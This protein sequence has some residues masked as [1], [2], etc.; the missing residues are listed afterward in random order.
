MTEST[1]EKAHAAL[2]APME[3][4]NDAG[5]ETVRAYLA[6]LLQTLWREEEGFNGKRPFGNSGWQSDIHLALVNAGLIP[7]TFDEDGCLDSVDEEAADAV[8]LA[9]IDELGRVTS[10]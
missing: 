10:R 7:G 4:D 5:A 2:A 9:A 1:A 3:D 8:L 6:K